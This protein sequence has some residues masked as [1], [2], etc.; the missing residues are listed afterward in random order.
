MEE[1]M[2]DIKKIALLILSVLLVVGMVF[3]LAACN[4]SGDP[5]DNNGDNG[6][7][8]GND[9]NNDANDG[10]DENNENALPEG[11]AEY[12]ILVVDGNGA[13][14]AGV[15]V[16]LCSDAGCQMPDATDANGI[17]KFITAE[18]NYKAQI[19]NVPNGYVSPASDKKF[20]LLNN[21]AIITVEKAASYVVT[22]NDQF[23]NPVKDAVVTHTGVD[24][25]ANTNAAGLAVFDC[26]DSDGYKVFVV[27]P[28][29]YEAANAVYTYAAGEKSLTVTLNKISEITVIVKDS[30][31][32]SKAGALVAVV[33]K[34]TGEVVAYAESANNGVARLNVV[35]NSKV[36]YE[37]VL[38]YLEGYTAEPAAIDADG[39]A[40]LTLTAEA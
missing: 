1:K 29:G 39:Y 32:A 37:V 10:S 6:N 38:V 35:E 34:A 13:P 12:T 19:A 30:A 28:A 16:Q 31:G 9:N 40:N 23:G 3:A 33:N 4:G 2:K 24:A 27:A 26:K 36:T 7:D 21:S 15:G 17:V 20:P 18:D 14:V 11:Q 25:C 22:V 5:A 8:N